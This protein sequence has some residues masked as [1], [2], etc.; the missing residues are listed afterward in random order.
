VADKL[1][2]LKTRLAELTD[3]RSRLDAAIEE[4]IAD[5]AQVPPEQRASGPW[6]RDGASTLKY[7]ELTTRQADIETEI[8]DLNRAIAET[9][10]E[11]PPS[12]L[13]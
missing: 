9:G 8:V 13:H 4:M 3:E 2:D 1:A 7:L 6:A 5:M 11:T 10:G 12:T